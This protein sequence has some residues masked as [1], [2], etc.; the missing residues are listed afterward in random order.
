MSS[1]GQSAL[2]AAA[3][4]ELQRRTGLIS[5]GSFQLAQAL[6][7]PPISTSL[8]T[9]TLAGRGFTLTAARSPDVGRTETTQLA[10]VVG[11]GVDR[12]VEGA[13]LLGR[14]DLLRVA[15]VQQR[16]VVEDDVAEDRQQAFLAQLHEPAAQL[17]AGEA[18]RAADD[19]QVAAQPPVAHQ[20]GRIG[21]GAPPVLRA[22]QVERGERGDELGGRG[23]LDGWSARNESSGRTVPST[24]RTS[25][26]KLLA[27]NPEPPTIAATAAAARRR[28]RPS[29]RRC[30]AWSR[31]ATWRRPARAPRRRHEQDHDARQI[32]AARCLAAR[33]G[34]AGIRAASRPASIGEARAVPA[35][36]S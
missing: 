2:P 7:P 14:L 10:L 23:E 19:D 20:P 36:T 29:P 27:G 9:S 26:A 34:R 3:H 6:Q 32:A 17:V 11:A 15:I 16:D 22:E 30:R 18:D 13:L 31:V 8:T 1:A 35:G 28:S 33:A 24:E 5:S 25:K 12:R 4:P 21:G